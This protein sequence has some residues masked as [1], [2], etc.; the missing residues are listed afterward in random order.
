[1]MSRTYTEVLCLHIWRTYFIQS[2]MQIVT[3]NLGK[4]LEIQNKAK[5][6]H[7]YFPIMHRFQ[8]AEC[9]D[10]TYKVEISCN[11]FSKMHV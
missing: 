7:N 3:K 4:Y 6:G 9:P 2:L 5:R 11:R 8:D 1:M 10:L